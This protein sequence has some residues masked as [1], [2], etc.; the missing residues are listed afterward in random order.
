MERS[1]PDQEIVLSYYDGTGCGI[2]HSFLFLLVLVGKPFFLFSSQVRKGVSRSELSHS[3]GHTLNEG[4]L[5][6]QVI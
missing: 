4:A 3:S 5:A 6:R 1:D 2:G